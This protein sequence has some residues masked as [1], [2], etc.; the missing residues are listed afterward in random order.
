MWREGTEVVGMTVLRYGF[1]FPQVC[2]ESG[3][4]GW[5]VYQREAV[6]VC[7]MEWDSLSQE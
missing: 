7:R 5:S 4:S 2:R 1:S 6:Y 3:I